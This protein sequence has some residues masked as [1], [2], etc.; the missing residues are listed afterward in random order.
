M[1]EGGKP[2]IKVMVVE[3]DPMVAELNKQYIEAVPGFR[4]AGQ[5][6]AEEVM[7]KLDDLQPD[8][9]LLDIYMP[10]LNGLELLKKL[11]AS[12]AEVDVIIISAANDTHSIQKAMRYGAVDYL[13]KPFHFERFQQALLS[14]K[15]RRQFFTVT[16]EVKQKEID[17]FLHRL[18]ERKSTVDL[19]K[20]LTKATLAAVWKAVLQEEEE[21]FSAEDVAFSS[22]VSRVSVRKYL[23]FLQEAGILSVD[24]SYGSVGRPQTR[25]RINRAVI[26]R[27]NQ[28]LN[29]HAD[30]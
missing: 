1:K 15:E 26:G 24:V 11:R 13:I 10:G 22:G 27:V 17:H 5:A 3:D 12:A 30:D 19:P 20:G 21:D 14:Y 18:R 16:E 9:L 7:E 29:V 25:Y 23:S 28:L 8:L 2:L 4:A 6:A